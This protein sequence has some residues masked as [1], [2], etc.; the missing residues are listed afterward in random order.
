M[1]TT[2]AVTSEAA[3]SA[4]VGILGRSGVLTSARATAPYVKGGRFGGGRVLAVLRPRTLVEA[5]R[6]LQV[7]VKHD[8]IVIPRPLIPG[9]PEAPARATSTTTARS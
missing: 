2:P 3:I 9:L 1:G 6:A 8:L 7:C 4:F 5:W